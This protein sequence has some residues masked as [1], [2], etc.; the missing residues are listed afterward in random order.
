M[1]GPGRI[2]SMLGAPIHPIRSM[3]T[4]THQ[5][6][7]P[8]AGSAPSR[9]AAGFAQALADADRCVLC[10]LCLPHCPTYHVQR[11]EG[12]SPR[13][14]IT[15]MLGLAQG[16][17]EPGNPRLRA[18]LEGCLSC[19]SCEAVCP[20]RV[21]FGALMDRSRKILQD[22][23]ARSGHGILE[24]ALAPWRR[25]VLRRQGLR[26]L[27]AWGARGAYRVGLQRL[28]PAST[29]LGRAL[30]HV[31]P[32]LVP[33][34][35][36]VPMPAQIPPRA[37]PDIGTGTRTAPP[38]QAD[39]W[40]FTGCMDAFF[41][42]PDAVA[43]RE[44][45]EALGLKV[46]LAQDQV[47]CG[48]LDQH[49]GRLHAA[50]ALQARNAQAFGATDAPIVV[51]DSGCE[52]HLRDEL[53]AGGPEAAWCGRVTSLTGF[54]SD[55]LAGP[56]LTGLPWR[57]DP[58]QV[59]LHLPCTLRNVTRETTGLQAVLERLPG[60]EVTAVT[61]PHNCCGAAGTAMLTQPAMADS[62]GHESLAALQATDAAIIISP[63]VGC[64]VHLRALGPATDK[65]PR[66]LSPAAFLR[67]RLGR[68]A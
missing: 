56:A 62:L 25:L 68:Q 22:H 28:L 23:P 26:R 29:R 61:P 66:I 4:P 12:D 45:L 38:A 27:A 31:G 63:N 10:G 21:P 3:P 51:L 54:L 16:Q 8:A 64:S 11:M 18:H 43:A 36:V 9:H 60:V 48:A 53:D 55:V 39:V 46:G 32:S 17:L 47:C 34:P 35:P 49:L 44:L 41:T 2:P 57:R 37:S 42:G 58:V 24:W 19:R 65:A 1:Q 59:A 20:A 5:S 40:L 15:L 33:M 6:A 30:R 67:E 50:A 13:G 52:A 14:R 7:S